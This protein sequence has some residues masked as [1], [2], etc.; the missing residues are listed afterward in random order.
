MSKA[1]AV[2]KGY[3]V[4]PDLVEAMLKVANAANS[5]VDF[6]TCDAGATWWEDNGMTHLSLMRHGISLK[7]QTHVTRN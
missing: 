1:A 6:I 4:A 5:E 7:A 3:G 2:I